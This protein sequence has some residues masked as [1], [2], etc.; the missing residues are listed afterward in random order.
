MNPH[1]I[2]WKFSDE[3]DVRTHEDDSRYYVSANGEY[4]LKLI[5]EVLAEWAITINLSEKI[6]KEIEVLSPKAMA[7]KYTID[8]YTRPTAKCIKY[9]GA[10]N[11]PSP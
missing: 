4:R 1:E 7:G 5:Q 2:T 6:T 3:D 9:V 8:L 10:K 11:A